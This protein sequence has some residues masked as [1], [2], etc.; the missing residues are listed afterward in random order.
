MRLGSPGS[1]PM[2]TGNRQSEIQNLVK[3]MILDELVHELADALARG[4]D[5]LVLAGD[6]GDEV[7]GLDAG[8]RALLAGAFLTGLVSRST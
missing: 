6:E 4:L 3:R 1:G 8:R 7:D 5:A 2:A